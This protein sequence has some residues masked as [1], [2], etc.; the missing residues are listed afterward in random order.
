[1]RPITGAVLVA[2]ALV[3][4][5]ACG[6]EQPNPDGAESRSDPTDPDRSPSAQAEID[7]A[8]K[9]RILIPDAVKAWPTVTL[10]DCRGFKPVGPKQLVYV[11][12]FDGDCASAFMSDSA[13][14]FSGVDPKPL[15]DSVRGDFEV[16]GSIQGHEVLVQVRGTEKI[17]AYSFSAVRVADTGE[18]AIMSVRADH[19]E[20]WPYA[21]RG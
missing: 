18:F 6:A 4:L 3:V 15:P 16:W 1:M 17:D 21:T 2:F 9:V 7:G 13:V 19:P 14:F 10:K 11:E 8:T 5:A 12:H 20:A